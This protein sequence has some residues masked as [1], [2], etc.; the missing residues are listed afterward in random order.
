MVQLE[1]VKERLV[2]IMTSLIEC[3]LNRTRLAE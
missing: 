2:M 1:V 3:T